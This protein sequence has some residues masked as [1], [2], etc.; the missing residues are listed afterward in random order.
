MEEDKNLIRFRTII[1]VL[2]KPKEHVENSLKSYIKQIKEDSEFMI[3]KEDYS[4]AQEQDNM[5]STFVELEIVVKSVPKLIGFCF[6]YMPSSLEIVKPEQLSI[7]N[8]HLSGMLN[9]LQAKLHNIDMVAKK[10]KNENDFLKINFRTALKNSIL[11]V[12]ATKKSGT[13]DEISKLSGI[14]LKELEQFLEELIKE[15]KI[16]KEE[17]IYSLK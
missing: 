5:F 7:K 16:K 6:D 17:D 4:E 9:D 11:I 13:L 2:G 3:M 10:L 15:E 14:V 8:T 1:E 12:L